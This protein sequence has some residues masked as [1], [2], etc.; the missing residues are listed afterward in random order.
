MGVDLLLQIDVRVYCTANVTNGNG[1]NYGGWQMEGNGKNSS[2][3][4]L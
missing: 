1:F 2:V 3:G 4:H